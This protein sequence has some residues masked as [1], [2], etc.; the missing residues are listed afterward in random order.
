MKPVV[1]ITAWFILCLFIWNESVL[2]QSLPVSVTA[3][4]TSARA[5]IDI[6][7]LDLPAGLG[8]VTQIYKAKGDDAPVV[9][10]IQNAHGVISAQKNI[11]KT[12]QY[13]QHKYGIDL[14]LVEGAEGKLDPLLLKTFPDKKIQNQVLGEY[15][16]RSEVTGAELAALLNPDQAHYEGLENW[17]VYEA[18]Y[19]AYM[20][21]DRSAQKAKEVIHKINRRLDGEREQVYSPALLEF[22][23]IHQDFRHDRIGLSGFL[24]HI[25][26]IKNNSARSYLKDALEQYS[27]VKALISVLEFEKETNDAAAA[28]DLKRLLDH[29]KRKYFE[30]LDSRQQQQWN[31]LAQSYS[32]E[33][34]DTSGYLK[35]ILQIADEVGV[36][37]KLP[38]SLE[39]LSHQNET[40]SMLK[41]T[42]L[43]HELDALVKGLEDV[44]ADETSAW[45]VLRQSRAM[46]FWED[47]SGLQLTRD[48]FSLYL[49]NPDKYLGVLGDDKRVFYPALDFYRL[50]LERDRVFEDKLIR[51]LNQSK[52]SG[53]LVVTGGFHRLGLESALKDKFNMAV[54]TP[55]IKSLKGHENY[56]EV[57][58]GQVSYA[59]YMDTTYYDAFMRHATRRLME[60]VTTN[61]FKRVLKIWRDEVIRE[62]SKQG[63]L[64]DTSV[65]TRYIDELYRDYQARLGNDTDDLKKEM[66]RALRHEVKA[67]ETE[68]MNTLWQNFENAFNQFVQ[69]LRDKNPLELS[70][71]NGIIDSVS[72]SK[73]TLE[74]ASVLSPQNRVFLWKQTNN[75]PDFDINLVEGLPLA[76]GRVLGEA[77]K[78]IASQP[79][80]GLSSAAPVQQIAGRLADVARQAEDIVESSESSGVVQ[81]DPAAAAQQLSGVVS[82]QAAREIVTSENFTVITGQLP[83]VTAPEAQV[84]DRAINNAETAARKALDAANELRRLRDEILSSPQNNES[85]I[86][87]EQRMSEFEE[88]VSRD[89]EV[90]FKQM[91]PY[92]RK[93]FWGYHV[94]VPVG[95][96]SSSAVMRNVFAS[97]EYSSN[98]KAY[99]QDK[100]F[101]AGFD[102]L[103]KDIRLTPEQFAYNI[104][105][106]YDFAKDHIYSASPMA[107]QL[108]REST[109]QKIIGSILARLRI[110]SQ[111]VPSDQFFYDSDLAPIATG[112]L[113]GVYPYAHPV[114]GFTLAAITHK[115][116]WNDPFFFKD[117]AELAGSYEVMES[118]NPIGARNDLP[119]TLQVEVKNPENDDIVVIDQ[120]L[121]PGMELGKALNAIQAWS[122]ADKIVLLDSLSRTIQYLHSKN[123]IHRDL[124]DR[125]IHIPQYLISAPG[126]VKDKIKIAPPVVFD[127]DISIQLNDDLTDGA[128]E[129]YQAKIAE[130]RDADKAL[131]GTWD[132]MPARLSDDSDP[133][134]H[135]FR[136]DFYSFG[137]LMALVF[138]FEFNKNELNRVGDNPSAFET[139]VEEADLAPE[140]KELL[141][142]LVG[143]IYRQHQYALHGTGELRASDFSWKE[144][145]QKLSA[146]H[147]NI[148]GNALRSESRSVEAP[149]L[150]A[151]YVFEPTLQGIAGFM[152]D[153]IEWMQQF[154]NYSEQEKRILN[155]YHERLNFSFGVQTRT[156]SYF[157]KS[158]GANDS[159]W[160]LTLN[161]PKLTGLIQEFRA[162]HQQEPALASRAFLATVGSVLYRE[163]MGLWLVNAVDQDVRAYSSRLSQLIR[164]IAEPSDMTALTQYLRRESDYLPEFTLGELNAHSDFIADYAALN[165]SMEMH[166]TASQRKF[167]DK[168]AEEGLFSADELTA[169]RS[170]GSLLADFYK[171]VLP[172]IDHS[173]TLSDQLAHNLL[174]YMRQPLIHM[175]LDAQVPLARVHYF[176]YSLFAMNEVGLNFA[177]LRQS[178]Y[179]D[180][181]T[182]E[183]AENFNAPTD[184]LRRVELW[185]EQLGQK[186]D[187]LQNLEEI[188][189]P[190]LYRMIEELQGKNA[191]E[192]YEV[193]LSH[194]GWSGMVMDENN[195]SI[196]YLP[197]GAM[198]MAYVNLQTDP[199]GIENFIR[200]VI[201]RSEQ[202]DMMLGTVFTD[203]IS[204]IGTLTPLQQVMLFAAVGG[205][206][207]KAVQLFNIAVAD[208][209]RRALIDYRKRIEKAQENNRSLSLDWIRAIHSSAQRYQTYD[210]QSRQVSRQGYRPGELLKARSDVYVASLESFNAVLDWVDQ[211]AEQ[212]MGFMRRRHFASVL[213]T[214]V[215]VNNPTLQDMVFDSLNDIADR[216][217]RSRRSFV[218]KEV[219]QNLAA[220]AK[221]TGR[222]STLARRRTQVRSE[223]RSDEYGMEMKAGIQALSK[224]AVELSEKKPADEVVMIAVDGEYGSGKSSFSNR[225]ESDDVLVIHADDFRDASQSWK[226]EWEPLMSRIE[227]ARTQKNYRAVI[228]EGAWIF[229]DK[230]ASDFDITVR[231]HSDQKSKFDN[232][233]LREQARQTRQGVEDI[234]YGYLDSISRSSLG[235][236]AGDVYEF[237]LDNRH[238]ENGGQGQLPEGGK[239]DLFT[240]WETPEF[241]VKVNPNGISVKEG[242]NQLKELIAQ[243]LQTKTDRTPIRI[244]IDGDWGVG[245]TTLTGQ[246]DINPDQLIVIHGDE[247][248]DR[249]QYMNVEL[250]EKT[251][252]EKSQGKDIKVII[253]ERYMLFDQMDGFDIRVSINADRETKVSNL[254]DREII[255]RRGSALARDYQIVYG[256]ADNS[257]KN[258]PGYRDQVYDLVLDNSDVYLDDRSNNRF[259]KS[260]KIDI[261]KR[262]EF[263]SDDGEPEQPKKNWWDMVRGVLGRQKIEEVSKAP[264]EMVRVPERPE[265]HDGYNAKPLNAGELNI[266]QF[267]ENELMLYPKELL[268]HR[269]LA[270]YL[271]D[272]DREHYKFYPNGG[273]GDIGYWV[274]KDFTGFPD[275]VP[276]NNFPGLVLGSWEDIERSSMYD[277][278]TQPNVG[279]K[280]HVVIRY[281]RPD[282]GVMSAYYF[283]N[284]AYTL[285]YVQ[286]AIE[287][288]DVPEVGNKQIFLDDHQDNNRMMN[289]EVSDTLN[290]WKD[291]IRTERL[292]LSNFNTFMAYLDIIAEQFWIFDGDAAA[293]SPQRRQPNKVNQLEPYLGKVPYT[294]LDYRAYADLANR[295]TADDSVILNWDSDFS[296]N[297]TGQGETLR[298]VSDHPFK[299][300]EEVLGIHRDILLGLRRDGIVPKTFHG[301]TTTYVNNQYGDVEI[302]KF[303]ARITP[304]IL[305]YPDHSDEAITANVEQAI[306]AHKA[307]VYYRGKPRNEQRSEQES[308]SARL[309]DWIDE[310][311]V[312]TSDLYFELSETSLEQAEQIWRERALAKRAQLAN[313]LEGL[314]QAAVMRELQDLP[315]AAAIVQAVTEGGRFS[316]ESLSQR[317]RSFQHR[318][319]AR[320]LSNR[321]RSAVA[322]VMAGVNRQD[323]DVLR[324][325]QISDATVRNARF[326]LASQNRSVLEGAIFEMT[327]QPVKLQSSKSVMMDAYFFNNTDVNQ[328]RKFIQKNLEA[329]SFIM[330]YLA[331]TETGD[332][333]KPLIR[334]AGM[335]KKRYDINSPL[336]VGESSV[337]DDVLHVLLSSTSVED[338]SPEQSEKG[339]TMTEALYAASRLN[340]QEVLP[341]VE[342]VLQ[343]D[344]LREQLEEATGRV[345]PRFTDNVLRTVFDFLNQLAETETARRAMMASA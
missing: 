146:A 6:S 174:I 226:I 17:D 153:S 300:V 116:E 54:I 110:P 82:P 268:H 298:G 156:S 333:L 235:D 284:H 327:G 195:I 209:D 73:A 285:P 176:Y 269:D 106:L 14:V 137:V 207:L 78:Q 345:F 342:L 23:Q 93:F 173:Q 187:S 243:A 218:R 30:R 98:F 188:P 278:D 344:F 179:D 20:Q 331:G 259:D 288:G 120:L 124:Q 275:N 329:G 39:R 71:F 233:I 77:L 326:L 69:K 262:S 5:L 254:V 246:M 307:N 136:R 155:Y 19:L 134:I 297:M 129:Y 159:I 313:G 70:E 85:L 206:V 225:F 127:F 185:L 318:L 52:A 4:D 49:E 270:A 160:S 311:T 280:R 224:R 24:A 257:Q 236:Y 133:L 141:L 158:S 18:N 90:F 227:Q 119:F 308:L 217:R 11:Q 92:T 59:E 101:I 222:E 147:Q 57:M 252:A 42:R 143:Q 45:D 142:R 175:V 204:W 248:S 16:N 216:T 1:K 317:L 229:Q 249:G 8:E 154:G 190:E 219:N 303:L 111:S 301:S 289:E 305:L 163:A 247:Y 151:D 83:L 314:L 334:T 122:P 27:S 274:S 238:E 192:M 61:D 167:V 165:L 231:I 21:A 41:G 171:M 56:E 256:M 157:S 291:F 125:N 88:R 294:G 263:R 170:R 81:R 135:D 139:R 241:I 189:K 320:D 53:V 177:R 104:N 66:M 293:H 62:L 182:A 197:W 310:G 128:T 230:S 335:I 283:D 152:Q 261:F 164:S 277:N 240:Y 323:D 89:L 3:Q 36:E 191:Y 117:A 258:Y 26:D 29:F 149:M 58:L 162:W 13:F 183:I 234:N 60:D 131:I 292:N 250:V 213:R 132:Y 200:N 33:E 25:R 276:G 68:T 267:T 50:A 223:Q 46:I 306:R 287:R 208:D 107:S 178:L 105:R 322:S 279:M 286:E 112:G 299:G 86:R 47:I 63:R 148:T 202:R 12:I 84:I 35:E 64:Q 91:L 338:V 290:G 340:A 109:R 221:K 255:Q 9:I 232:L 161:V 196:S 168:V 244:G 295:P 172:H 220:L 32:V 79:R 315:N 251:I 115:N 43:M 211:Q 343:V 253:V 199:K 126:D 201:A 260:A 121:P 245:K 103:I 51:A 15:L 281:K 99:L 169:L 74:T 108:G 31:A 198:G 296:W 140:I 186:T 309:L 95:F 102:R 130:E 22:H 48:Q 67:F 215:S 87:A 113:R 138:G 37:A 205:A 273:R 316:G 328:S 180:A 94:P 181:V 34:L 319:D 150:D 336:K 55:A 193:I 325:L 145:R 76:T 100:N 337:L 118:L 341:L 264:A 282:G 302:V 330:A 210:D 237:E 2:S 97:D 339:V 96:M 44:L 212:D 114:Y 28:N 242:V 184:L 144:V 80:P 75:I 7:A 321:L 123:F 266:D 194:P 72:A 38:A 228:V 166:E 65:Y 304:Y 239:L 272:Y 332:Y 265:F 214:L 10:T 203:A 271:D 312:F 40:V 324:N